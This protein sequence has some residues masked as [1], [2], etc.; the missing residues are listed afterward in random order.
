MESEIVQ[1]S[2][3]HM[4]E[5]FDVSLS[6]FPHIYATEVLDP[7]TCRAIT[8]HWPPFDAMVSEITQ[9]RYLY[10]LVEDDH[11][12]IDGLPAD[13]REFWHQT[14]HGPIQSVMER[15]A[16]A[17]APF[18]AAKFGH[19]V[20][21]EIPLRIHRLMCLQ[22]ETEF[23]EH[24]PHTHL[25]APDWVFTFLIYIDDE[26][27]EDR[28]TSLYGVKNPDLDAEFDDLWMNRYTDATRIVEAQRCHFGQ[29]ALCAF[30]DSPFS[31]HGSTPFELKRSNAGR[32]LLRA[33]VALEPA[34]AERIYGREVAQ[35]RA[36]MSAAITAYHQDQT[37]RAH[38][39]LVPESDISNV[40]G[41][42]TGRRPS[43]PNVRIHFPA[44][45]D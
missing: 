32:R 13:I 42:L 45:Q 38:R 15:I 34:E 8:E 7:E 44:L 33:H 1:T 29:G 36:E 40:R 22:A 43:D 9:P 16:D 35:L 12:R 24:T 4:R 14:L 20:P 6:P 5:R 11:V 3:S 31:I 25:S 17:F 39:Q 30:F 28:G 27:Q 37:S 23:V 2:P 10:E 21:R 18:I 41:F 26:G 19:S